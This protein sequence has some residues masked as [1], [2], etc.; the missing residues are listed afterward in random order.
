DGAEEGRVTDVR[1]ARAA[2]LVA[3][4]SSVGGAGCDEKPSAGGAATSATS[5]TSAPTSRPSAA[6]TAPASASASAAPA[7][8]GSAGDGG[9]KRFDPKYSCP[10]GMSHFYFEGDFCRRKCATNAD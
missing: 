7:T 2:V 4:L 5:A 1:R 9:E 3:C 6:V 10:T 8:S